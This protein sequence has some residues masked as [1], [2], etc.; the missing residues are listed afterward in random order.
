M[1][2]SKDAFTGSI[3]NH[4]K[5]METNVRYQKEKE[6]RAKLD[7][8]VAEKDLE[9]VL[10]LI[11]D[12]EADLK[13]RHRA[14]KLLTELNDLECID[15]IRAHKFHHTE[16]GQLADLAI[17]GIL[18]NHNRRECAHCAEIV[19]AQAKI[20]KHCGRENNDG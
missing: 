20:C 15:P 11:T 3:V 12:E 7:T 17:N 14:C 9:P 2:G 10:C 8:C 19:K 5:M 6:A 1:V 18:K 16:I 4:D 13:S